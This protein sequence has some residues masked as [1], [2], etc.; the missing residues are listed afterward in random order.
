MASTA[1]SIPAE[2]VDKQ[3]QASIAFTCALLRIHPRSRE[4]QLFGEGTSNP[5]AAWDSEGSAFVE[6][7]LVIDHLWHLVE[8][9][10]LPPPGGPYPPFT[11]KIGSI[12][13]HKHQKAAYCGIVYFD[14]DAFPKKYREQLYMG[15]IHGG[16]INVD[17]LSAT[18]APTSPRPSP[19]S[20]PPT[21][22]GSC[23]S[24]QKTGPDGCLY[25]LDWYDRYHCYQDANR[26]PGGSTGLKG[27]LYRVRYNDTPR[28]AKFDLA[29]ES[30]EQLVARLS[31]G[32]IYFRDSAQRLLNERLS[33][34]DASPACGSRWRSWPKIDERPRAKRVCM[35]CGR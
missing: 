4:F 32:N 30:D 31:S 24:S 22:R 34:K 25:V 28:A 10:Y 17:R 26:D 35:P 33:Q 11:W 6:A 1:C 18:A 2:I 29:N 20:S 12:V 21:T 15:N 8:T 7:C 27:R 13:E 5:G 23:R 9:G 19:T 3:R 14:S 16:C